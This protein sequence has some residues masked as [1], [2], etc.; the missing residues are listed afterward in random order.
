MS[1]CYAALTNEMHN[2]QINTLIQFLNF[3]CLLHV[4]NRLE[5]EPLKF[6]T[7]RRHQKLKNLMKVLI[8]KVCISLVHDA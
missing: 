4:S 3:L 5:N 1:E 6:E 8:L 2:F 7:R